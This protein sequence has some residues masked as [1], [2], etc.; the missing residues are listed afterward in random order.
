MLPPFR[1]RTLLLVAVLVLSACSSGQAATTSFDP[2]SAC[3]T[4]GRFAG[5]YPDLEALVPATYRGDRPESLD[6]GRNCTA[7]QLGS[8]AAAGIR[9]VE[10]GGGTWTFGAERALVMAVFRGDGL[11]AD[12]LAAFY[13]AGAA[14]NSRTTIDAQTAPT[15]AGRP[16][17]R[18]DTTTSER[19]QTVVTWPSAQPKMVNVVITN[20]L[21]DAR[22]QDAIDAFGGR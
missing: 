17:H 22:I 21:P 9:E 5:A 12:K 18:L 4:D 15:V 16:G 13:A 20:D 7:A 14:A 3:T 8:L 2:K 10:F 11:D 6:S 19:S 1:P